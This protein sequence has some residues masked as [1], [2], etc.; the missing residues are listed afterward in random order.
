MVFIIILLVVR[1]IWRCGNFW[2]N[3]EFKFVFCNRRIEIVFIFS[4]I[5]F[6]LKYLFLYILYLLVVY[7]FLYNKWLMF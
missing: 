6:I 3:R 7:I 5:Y 2:W 1:R 4:I